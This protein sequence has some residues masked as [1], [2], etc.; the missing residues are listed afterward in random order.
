MPD[1]LHN[2]KYLKPYRKGLRKGL[3]IAEA[4]LWKQ[5]KGK[6]LKGRKFRRQHSIGRYIVDFYCPS[7]NLVIELD[8]GIHDEYNIY[9][10]DIGK[11]EFLTKKDLFFLSFPTKRSVIRWIM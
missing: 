2:R 1:K 5:L 11:R 4:R 10:K 8:G 7:E 6:G 3:T 9:Q